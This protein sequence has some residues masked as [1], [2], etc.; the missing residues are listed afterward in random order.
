MKW[1][2]LQVMTGQEDAI[3]DSLLRKDIHAAVPHE[4]RV[5]RSGGKWLERDYILI[6]SYVFVQI[7]YTDAL[8]YV[9]KSTQGVIRWLGNGSRPSPL[10]PD[11]EAWVQRWEQPLVP[12][13][14]H[15]ARDGTYQ[16]IDGPLS[17][18]NIRLLKIDRHRRRA[19]VEINILGQPKICYL[20][21]DVLKE[22]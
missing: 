1:Y 13:K 18:E 4:R 14:V 15:F 8:Y 17:G 2:V 3:R 16:V 20:S 6:P 11:E 9:L 19:K 22:F 12:S 5:L 10:F 7:E 21:L